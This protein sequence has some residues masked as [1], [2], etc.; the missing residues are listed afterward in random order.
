MSIFKLEE[1]HIKNQF[2]ANPDWRQVFLKHYPNW[3]PETYIKDALELC[4]K[5]QCFFKIVK[6]GSKNPDSQ[7][8]CIVDVEVSLRGQWLYELQ[9]HEKQYEQTVLVSA[10]C[11]YDID[12]STFE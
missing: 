8:Y 9:V 11:D 4:A 1:S 10:I 6:R 2:I 7:F 3:T 12:F 5:N